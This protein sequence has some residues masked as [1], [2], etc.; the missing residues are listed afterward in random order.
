MKSVLPQFMCLCTAALTVFGNPIQT[1]QQVL[2]V[3]QDMTTQQDN[4]V[5][6]NKVPGNNDAIYDI[7][8][9]KD[10]IFKVEFLDRLFFLYLRGYIPQSRTAELAL[11]NEGLVDAT[12]TIG[13][14]VVYADGSHDDKESYTIPL[15]TTSFNNNGHIAIRDAHGVEVDYLPSSGNG[16]IL[17][18]YWIPGMFMK[19]GT[20]TFKVDARAGDVDNTRL[21]AM[22]LTQGLEGR[23]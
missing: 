7:I 4:K 2:V 1:A 22:S 16:G 17:V 18:D 10:Q 5:S 15:K 13:A 19:S 3:G 20:W 8:P 6:D 23:L 12:V 11:T 21:F 14:S 9:D